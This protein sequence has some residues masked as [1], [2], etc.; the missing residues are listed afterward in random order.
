MLYCSVHAEKSCTA[1]VKILNK[2]KYI[3][4]IYNLR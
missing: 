4:G 1:L 2:I 3:L